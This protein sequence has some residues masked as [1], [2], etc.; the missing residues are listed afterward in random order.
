LEKIVDN[1]TLEEDVRQKASDLHEKFQSWKSSK[2]TI[3]Y[4]RRFANR[5]QTEQQSM[6][7]TEDYL[8]ITPHESWSLNGFADW[9]ISCERFESNRMKILDYIKKGLEKIIDNTKLEE[10][11]RQ[12]ASDLHE[13][14]QVMYWDKIV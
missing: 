9:C 8:Q 4:F 12:K 11:I 14:F 13:E 5:Y 6:T 10:D 1:T 7:E 3:E 2:V